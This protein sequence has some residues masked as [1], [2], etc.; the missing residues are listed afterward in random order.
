MPPRKQLVA[1]LLTALF[2][3]ATLTI[4]I[5][6]DNGDGRPD[7]ITITTANGKRLVATPEAVEAGGGV[8]AERGLNGDGNAGTQRSSDKANPDAPRI[9]GPVPN[10]SP[11]QRG[12]L[13]RSNTANFSYRNGTKPSIIPLHETV[14]ANAPGWGDVNGLAVFLNRAATSASANYIIDNEGHCVY[15]VAESLKAW[16]QANYNSASACSFE[17]INT[18]NE[19]TYAGTEGL[20]KLALVV[21]DCAKRWGIPLRRARVSGC[22]VLSAGVIDHYH[23][24]ACGGGH[25]DVHNF[26]AGCRNQGPS[27]DTW[28]CVDTVIAVARQLDRPP[29][30]ARQRAKCQELNRIRRAGHGKST[31]ARKIRADQRAHHLRCL[32]T[33]PGKL[34]RR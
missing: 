24:G 30:T 4:V 13:T 27:A 34:E 19:A 21:H 6:D 12:C 32:N 2:G 14:S 15:T 17:V 16:T 11:Y 3:I 29:I 33:R 9:S 18:G 28:L 26:G 22:T 20:K 8:G 31:R 5:S 7:R 25:F 10:A 1:A 23:L